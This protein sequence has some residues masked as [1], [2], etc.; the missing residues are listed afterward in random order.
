MSTPIIRLDCYREQQ[1]AGRWPY[2]CRV[3][4]QNSTD[5]KMLRTDQGTVRTF[6]TLLAAC[7]AGR[8]AETESRGILI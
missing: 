1:D 2:R 6:P 8:I 7:K 4:Y 3:M 5:W